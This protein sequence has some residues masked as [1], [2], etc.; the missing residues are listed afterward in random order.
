MSGTASHTQ[1][2]VV[3]KLGSTF[4]G[5]SSERGDFEHWFRDAVADWD[6]PVRIL[7]AAARPALPE[8]DAL[9][10]VILTGSSSMVTDRL[11]WSERLRPWLAR[12]VAEGLPV[13]GVCYGHQLLADALGGEV[14]RRSQGVEIGSVSV[15]RNAD[16]DGDPLFGALPRQFPAHCVH[17]QSVLRLPANACVLAGSAADSHQAYR[18]GDRAWGVQF[19][20]EFSELVMRFY[21]DAYVDA[22][23]QDGLDPAH[24]HA[25]VQP[26]ADSARLLLAFA[27]L[28]RSRT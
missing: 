16:S 25:E 11:P 7:D 1:P 10:G 15:T 14:G 18:V 5:L 3:V 6:L 8:P 4:P 23:T 13:L 19:H 24:L 17:W 27:K 28:C 2:L 20:P 21:I 26:T 9:A 12:I 22:L